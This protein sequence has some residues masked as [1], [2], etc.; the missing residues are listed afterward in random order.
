MRYVNP[1]PV[2]RD[3]SIIC[4]DCGNSFVFTSGEQVFFY[5]R[6]LS[7]PKR[8]GPCRERRRQAIPSDYRQYSRSWD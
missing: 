3:K 8:C 1:K 2:Y 6:G 5:D 4:C 7:E